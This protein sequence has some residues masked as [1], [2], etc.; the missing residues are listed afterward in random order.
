MTSRT[1]LLLVA[2]AMISAAV[3]T[4]HTAR[5]T[6][7]PAA[8]CNDDDGSEP[9]TSYHYW[10]ST[11]GACYTGQS[12]DLPTF[13]GEHCGTHQLANGHAAHVAC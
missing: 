5:G 6:D 4:P 7:T 12:N 8:R 2:T 13:T 9:G 10:N 1:K 3:I 11:G